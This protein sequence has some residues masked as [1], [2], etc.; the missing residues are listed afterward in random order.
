[1]NLAAK[2]EKLSKSCNDAVFSID[3]DEVMGPSD[4]DEKNEDDD[5]FPNIE[6][7]ELESLT[8]GLTDDD[9][10]SDDRQVE[11]IRKRIFSWRPAACPT[12]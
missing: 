8:L 7:E 6:N 1:M 5:E 2:I 10:N 12:V 11:E 4:D 9:R 3:H